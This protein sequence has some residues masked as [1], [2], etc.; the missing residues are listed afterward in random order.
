[1]TPNSVHNQYNLGYAYD[2]DPTPMSNILMQVFNKE[3]TT[4]KKISIGRF[5]N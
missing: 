1:M 3:I 4:E 5:I 2:T